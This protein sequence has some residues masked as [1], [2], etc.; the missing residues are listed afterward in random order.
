M[1]LQLKTSFSEIIDSELCTGC[2]LLTGLRNRMTELPSSYCS[3]C[4]VPDAALVN[5]S[6]QWYYLTQVFALERLIVVT[7]TLPTD[8]DPGQRPKLSDFG[9]V[10]CNPKPVHVVSPCFVAYTCGFSTAI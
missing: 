6:S 8:R 4:G 5:S 3:I 7:T 2:I 10:N 1:S 9:P